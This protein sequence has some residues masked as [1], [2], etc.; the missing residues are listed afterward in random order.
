M[1]FIR[2]THSLVICGYELHVP[3]IFDMRHH[4]RS[5][6]VNIKTKQMKTR[7]ALLIAPIIFFM[8]SCSDT[9]VSPTNVSNT[10][11]DGT[12]KVSFYFDTDHEETSDFDGYNIVFSANNVVNASNGTTSVE[13]TWYV[14]TTGSGDE[15]DENTH[16]VLHFAPNIPFTELN[17]DWLILEKT[18]TKVH[19]RH[20][21]GGGGGTDLLT[22]TKL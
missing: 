21:S 17:D 8:A 14:S 18:L 13:G 12:W 4:F 1:I 10:L 11:K 15:I 9:K 5:G 19:M 6:W 22:F 16:L 7:I 3:H 20:E 2:S